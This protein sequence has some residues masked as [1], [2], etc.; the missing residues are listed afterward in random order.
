MKELLFFRDLEIQVFH[1]HYFCD[2]SIQCA[3]KSHPIDI[4]SYTGTILQHIDFFVCDISSSNL[5]MLIL[6]LQDTRLYIDPLN[7]EITHV[8]PI[9]ICTQWFR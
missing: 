6:I 2:Q 4:S 7:E 9:K 5:F 3:A 1:R 8:N